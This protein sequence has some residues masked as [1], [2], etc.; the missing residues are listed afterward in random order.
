MIVLIV[1]AAVVLLAVAATAVTV[2]VD[3][4]RKVRVR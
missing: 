3:G 1:F 2:Y 4:Y